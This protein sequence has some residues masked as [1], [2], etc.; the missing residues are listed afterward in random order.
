MEIYPTYR[1]SDNSAHI[2]KTV[3][4][5]MYFVTWASLIS[6]KFILK[7]SLC[8][9]CFLSLKQIFVLSCHSM[10]NIATL[11]L[12]RT[13]STEISHIYHDAHHEGVGGSGAIAPFIHRLGARWRCVAI[14]SKGTIL[15]THCAKVCV[16]TA[17]GL[18]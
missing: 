15:G 14:Y 18:D 8:G 1:F 4:Y 3:S 5:N 9:E 11:R 13:I 16:D 17:D 7:I 12:Y 10:K 2:K 6:A